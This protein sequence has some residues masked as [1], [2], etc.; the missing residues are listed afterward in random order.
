MSRMAQATDEAWA[1]LVKAADNMAQF[2]DIHQH[3]APRYSIGDNVWL[4]SENIRM[5]HPTKKLNYKWLGPYTINQVISHNAYRLKL[6]ASFGQ[7]HPVFS[8]TLLRP[9]DD[10]P[11]TECQECH[12]PPLPLIICD[13]VEE[14]EV[15]KILDSRIFCGKVEYLVCWKGYGV[16]EDEWQPSRDIQGSKQLV[17]EFHCTH[18]HAHCP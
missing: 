13:G 11:I 6:P 4:S 12:L 18:P 1:A 16:E 5:T 8:V 14:Y 10:D 7:V 17:T 2:Y 15:E 9:Y 3:K